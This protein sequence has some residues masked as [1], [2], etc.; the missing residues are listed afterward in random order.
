VIFIAWIRWNAARHGA[1]ESKPK[2]QRRTTP[3]KDRA[4]KVGLALPPTPAGL[5]DRIAESTITD[6]R[7][8]RKEMQRHQK[9]CQQKT[10]RAEMQQAKESAKYQRY[11]ARSAVCVTRHRNKN[12]NKESRGLLL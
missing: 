4:A 7:L 9:K 8:A 12:N 5:R 2:R 3:V 11:C 6:L 10:E 1:I